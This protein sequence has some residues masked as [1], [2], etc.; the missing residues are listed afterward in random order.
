[1][2]FKTLISRFEN[3]TVIPEIRIGNAYNKGQNRGENHL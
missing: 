3:K 1:M 2:G